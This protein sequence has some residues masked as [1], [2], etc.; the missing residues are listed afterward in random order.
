MRVALDASAYGIK[1]RPALIRR[2]APPR[3]AKDVPIHSPVGT[4]A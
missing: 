4:A 2:D 3:E 1:R